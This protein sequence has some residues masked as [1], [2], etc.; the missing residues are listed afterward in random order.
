MNVQERLANRAS[1]PLDELAK[2][3]GGWV[4]WD[5]NGTRVVAHGSDFSATRQ[6]VCDVGEDPNSVT[7]E[8]I[9]PLEARLRGT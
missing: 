7:F 8:F 1:F 2:Y 9:P 3:A 4:A 5:P 6:T